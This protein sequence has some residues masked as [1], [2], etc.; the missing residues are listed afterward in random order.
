M[1]G[2]FPAIGLSEVLKV[3][4]AYDPVGTMYIRLFVNNV[5]PVL[6]SV[7]TDFTACSDSGYADI[8]LSA[9]NWVFSGG[10]GE[11]QIA[12][13]PVVTFGPIIGSQTVYGALLYSSTTSLLA[14]AQLAGTPIPISV[15][16]VLVDVSLVWSI[17]NAP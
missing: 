15:G 1:A 4:L 16:G 17:Q 8:A 10:S 9:V 13:Y 3:F 11:P 6:S 5:T 14:W 7:L 2:I 12:T